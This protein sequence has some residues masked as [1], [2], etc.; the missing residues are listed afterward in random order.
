MTLSKEQEKRLSTIK[1]LSKDFHFSDQSIWYRV[2][3]R[4]SS[5]IPIRVEIKRNFYDNQSWAY[6][7][8]FDHVHVAWNIIVDLPFTKELKCFGS[9]GEHGLKNICPFEDDEVTLIMRALDLL[10]TSTE[11]K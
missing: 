9:S 5:N 3:Y 8:A 11:K 7:Y 2:A 6:V 10:E 1:V 4:T